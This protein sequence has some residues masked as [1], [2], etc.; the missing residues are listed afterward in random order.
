MTI[1]FKNLSPPAELEAKT[2]RLK[3]RLEEL[4][5]VVVAFSAGVDSTFLAAMS[6]RVLGARALAVTASSPAFPERELEEARGLAIELGLQ[7]RVIRSNELANPNYANNP[8][9]RCYHCKTELYGL[10]S[11]IAKAE[12]YAAVVDGTNADDAGDFRPGRKAADELAVV[13]PLLELGFSKADIRNASQ[14][15]GLKTST[16]PAFACMASRFPYGV[17]ITAESLRSVEKAENLLRD[18]GFTQVRVRVLEDT[19]RLE[20]LPEEIARA[21]LPE[22]RETIYT[23]LRECGFKQVVLD[24]AGY[25]QGSLNEG[26]FPLRRPDKT[27][28][29]RKKE[30]TT[31]R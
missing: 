24:L 4:G 3:R 1:T 12:G 21:A 13:S 29:T 23:G 26:L 19:A 6:V 27:E 31:D 7:H 20:L 28:T 30:P 14:L 25:R 18:L 5:S 8:T 16:K 10:L 9:S 22:F 17:K 2:E 15:L 11:E